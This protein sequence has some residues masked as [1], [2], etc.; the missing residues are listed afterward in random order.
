MNEMANAIMYA[1]LSL[2]RPSTQSMYLEQQHVW[3]RLQ[4]KTFQ[5]ITAKPSQAKLQ[6]STF[7]RDVFTKISTMKTNQKRKTMRRIWYYCHEFEFI[8]FIIL[9]FFLAA[10]SVAG[11]SGSKIKR[12]KFQKFHI[13]SL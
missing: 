9:I 2:Q 5:T 7:Y 1:S 11:L 10:M 13:V 8:P 12:N 4:T 6:Q 3:L